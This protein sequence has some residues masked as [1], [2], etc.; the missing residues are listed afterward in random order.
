MNLSHFSLLAFISALIAA[1]FIFDLQ[2]YLTLEALKAQ[3]EAIR[4]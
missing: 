4:I 2:S 3:Q 1:F